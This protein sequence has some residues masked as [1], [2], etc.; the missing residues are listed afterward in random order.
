VPRLTRRRAF[1]LAGAATALA[2]LRPAT[3]ASFTR[4]VALPP[5]ARIAGRRTLPPQRA[6]RFDL[7]G[8]DFGPAAHVHSEVRARR[9]GGPWSPWTPVH[10]ATQPVWTGPADVFQV[11][12]TGAARRLRARFVRTGPAPRV[13]RRAAAS[14]SSGRP[15][16]IRRSGWGGD[17]LPR[18]HDPIYGTVELGFVHHTVTANDYD[19]EDSAGIVLGIAK[20]HRDH[21][22]WWDIGYQFLC[23]KY[24][25]IFE[26]R[27]GGMELA[28]VGAQAQGYNSV[29]TGISCLGDYSSGQL[30]PDGIEA[31]ARLLAWKL[32][33]HGVPVKGKVTVTSQGGETNRYAP[34]RRVTLNRI[35]GHRDGDATSCPGTALY[36][37]LSTIRDRA[38]A[39]EVSVPAL[40]VGVSRSELTYPDTEVDLDGVLRFDDAADPTGAAIQ[41]QYRT[42]GGQPWQVVQTLAADPEGAFATTLSV[43]ASGHL[44][45]VHPA[46][47]THA[48]LRSA[49][50]AVEVMPALSLAIDPRKVRAGRGTTISATADPVEVTRGRL[51]IQRRV[52]GRYRLVSGRTVEIVDG[53]YERT[54]TP[55]KAGHYRVTFRAGGATVR[56]SLRAV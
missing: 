5:G 43:A 30:T 21:N 20:Y 54:F 39:L 27:E 50:V 8:L 52:A 26:G 37:Q 49:S 6:P 34:G 38:E 35:S 4:D 22:G 24:G 28:V 48:E 19:P 13:T 51:V 32:A 47:A 16:I 1:E 29:S 31:V 7:I 56:R 10:D 18:K 53:A 44:R 25:Q 11:R 55:S 41:V 12:F 42:G 2:A 9:R 33:L 40:T 46:D 45:A 23:D 17:R 14:A 3:A 15:P 36:A